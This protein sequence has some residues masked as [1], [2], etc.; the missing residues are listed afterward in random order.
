MDDLKNKLSKATIKVLSPLIRI[1]LRFEV[2]H[3]EFSELAKQ[4]YVKTAYQYFS[5]P[6]RKNTYSRVSVL[7]GLS[8]KEVVRLSQI[9][10]KHLV[11]TKGPLN[12]ATRVITGWVRDEDFIDKNKQPKILPLRGAD[13]SF[14][15]LAN[16]YSGDITSRAILD[17]LIRVGAV[18]KTDKHTVQLQQQA[19]IPNKSQTELLEVVTDHAAD[20][21]STGVHNIMTENDDPRFQRQVIYNDV[22]EHIK[23]EFEKMSQEKSMQLLIELDKWLAQK[24]K[25]VIAKPD[26][27]RSRVGVG[28]YY[29]NNETENKED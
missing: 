9:D 23:E 8:R 4:A 1:L 29:F 21:L 27:K 16:R 26:E 18:H 5:I 28:I 10:E 3:S 22:P 20:L 2:S 24:K 11:E 14:E 7:T 6:N 15:T 13:I 17:E 19:Y 12:R 25:T